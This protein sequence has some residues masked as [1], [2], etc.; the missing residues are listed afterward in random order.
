MT[1][2]SKK[3]I[4]TAAFHEKHTSEEV[5]RDAVT[6]KF[7]PDDQARPWRDFRVQNAVRRILRKVVLPDWIQNH[8]H[9]GCYAITVDEWGRLLCRAILPTGPVYDP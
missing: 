3:L 1:G 6:V 9:D 7:Y 2:L 8:P 5:E 4:Q